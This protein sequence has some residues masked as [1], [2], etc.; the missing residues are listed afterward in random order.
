MALL[1]SQLA[2]LPVDAGVI[3]RWLV[4]QLANERE[5]WLLWAPVVFA[6][7]IGV[8]FALS[9]EPPL[10]L[11]IAGL[12]LAA[13]IWMLGRSHAGAVIL[14][15]GMAASALGWQAGAWATRQAAAPVVAD[16]LGPVLLQGQVIA[17][18]PHKGGFRVMF[19]RL[20]IEG[21]APEQT[22][23]KVRITFRVP[24]L[25]L[26]AGCW[27]QVL[28]V[29]R[30]PPEPAM[31]GAFDFA[32][33]AWFQ[34]LGGVG[35]AL[36]RPKPVAAPDEP[37]DWRSRYRLWLVGVR[38]D[39]TGRIYR[40]LPGE[41]GAIAA[42]LMTGERGAIPEELEAAY[43]DSGLAHL[44]SISGLH[45]TLVAGILFFAVRF[46]L[47]LWERVALTRPIKKW[48]AVAALG[49]AFAYLQVSGAAVPTQRAFVMASIV[50]LAVLA[51]RQAI[52][53]RSVGLAAVLV[54]LLAPQSLLEPSFQ[55]S[56]AAVV[57]LIAAFESARHQL[58]HWRAHGG[59]VRTS[60][61]YLGMT[62]MTTLVA[63]SATIPFAVYHFNRFVDFGLI[64]NLLGVP[65]ASLWVMPAAM[66][67][68]VLMPMGFEHWPLILAG[69]GIDLIN[70]IARMVASWPG[71]VLM[72]PAMP[73]WGLLATVGG[74]LW[75]CL[76]R[77]A[78]RHAGHLAI[79]VGLASPW[80]FVPPDI[81]IDNSGRV[82]VRSELGDLIFLNGRTAKGMVGET[83]LR[84]A[85]L[86]KGMVWSQKMEGND[87][88][89]DALGCV[90]R[91]KGLIAAI[92]KDRA[93]LRDDCASAD[94]VLASFYVGRLCQ[95]PR[96][97]IDRSDLERGHAFA[98][99]LDAERRIDVRDVQ[100]ERGQRPW[101]GIG[102]RR[103]L[104]MAETP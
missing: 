50:L 64:A 29:L 83:W 34:G 65:I 25:D 62:A 70:A 6:S 47:A 66:A 82:A 99:W 95:G 1:Q 71:A 57:A 94:V 23:E 3:Y 18:Q 56:F 102:V 84:R 43:R 45:L 73:L 32:R 53:M 2:N 79:V 93:A 7:G 46:A 26:R 16:G 9:F 96:V 33:S 10:W 81:L 92:P 87:L 104:R 35:Y 30:P 68:F 4:D 24:A 19:D 75:L 20:E 49:G 17:A 85:G 36:T 69:F 91:A 86:E 11:G 22:P 38:E 5:R 89:C 59:V 100:S 42:A 90:Y 13:G 52:S 37:H 97:V 8:Y 51:D 27:A 14:A 28:A 40:A 80:G 98:L 21:L 61:L 48:A 60:A 72:V 54:L 101:V 67:A 41:T 74:G 44:L 31:P 58:P 12:G 76:W 15:F 103:G 63:G 88:G 55:M 78:W 77:R 39:L